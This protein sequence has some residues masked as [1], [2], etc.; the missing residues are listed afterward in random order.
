MAERGLQYG[1]G[2][3]QDSASQLN[4]VDERR[5]AGDVQKRWTVSQLIK[6][7]YDAGLDEFV[8]CDSTG[9]ALTVTLPSAGNVEAG[10]QVAVKNASSST[11]VITVAARGTETING[12]ASQTINTAYEGAWFISDGSNWL[13]VDD[14][15]QYALL[16]GRSGGQMLVGGT[17]SGEDLTLQSTAH[18]TKG[19]LLFGTSAYDEVNNRLGVGTTG[20]LY[21]LHAQADAAASF[22]GLFHN[23]GGEV[24][25][26][27]VAVL[28]GLDDQ[29]GATVNYCLHYR[30]GDGD[31]HGYLRN[32]NGT[33]EL[34]Q[35]SDKKRKEDI[36]DT[37][38]DALTRIADLKL[39]EFR[40]KTKKKETKGALHPIGFIAQDVQDV[41][42]E[43]VTVGTDG[44]LFLAQSALIPYLTKAIQEQQEQIEQLQQQ[45]AALEES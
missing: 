35:A 10:K 13:M 38:V 18:A 14:H 24:N 20:P 23:D 22:V 19:S 30:D 7:N 36:R 17:G 43:A 37:L 32:N 4:S 12:S 8:R 31:D 6:N 34:A 42:P 1:R 29:S 39:K 28:S 33:F 2:F 11:N 16:A 3:H 21:K 44:S 26:Y 25:R 9:G 27:G 15:S 45:V 5:R 40:Y 41:I